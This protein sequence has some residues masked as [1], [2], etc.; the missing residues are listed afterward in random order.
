MD[1]NPKANSGNTSIAERLSGLEVTVKHLADADKRFQEHVDR[2]YHKADHIKNLL[3][4]L[5]GAVVM[6]I[7]AHFIPQG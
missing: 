6:N 7:A 3:I 2:L 5:L 4:G 1:G